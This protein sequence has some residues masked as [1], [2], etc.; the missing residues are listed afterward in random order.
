MSANGAALEMAMVLYLLESLQMLPLA[1]TGF[2]GIGIPWNIPRYI[3]FF[4]HA[5]VRAL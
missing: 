1:C 5:I 2:Q 4:C 3:L